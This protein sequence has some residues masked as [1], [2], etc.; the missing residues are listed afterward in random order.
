MKSFIICVFG[1]MG[2]S[3]FSQTYQ[4]IGF[5]GKDTLRM[6]EVTAD[7]AGNVVIDT[8]NQV[9]IIHLI[10]QLQAYQ[11][12]EAHFNV[13]DRIDSQ[14][15]FEAAKNY[16]SDSLDFN[17]L[18]HTPL[19]KRYLEY[20]VG[21]YLQTSQTP[22]AFSKAFVPKVKK[23]IQRTAFDYPEVTVYLVNNLL[24]FFSQYGLD[25]TAIEV[26][27]YA[28]GSDFSLGEPTKMAARILKIAHLIDHP[29]PTVVGLEPPATPPSFTLLFFYESGCSNCEEQIAA[30]K[31]RYSEL[32]AKGYRVASL[33][34]DVNKEVFAYHSKDFPW[35]DKLCDFQGF[36][37][38]N[39]KNY[40]VSFTPCIFLLDKDGIVKGFYA[41]LSDILRQQN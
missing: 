16:V 28:Y 29:A 23:V 26:A 5:A 17:V 38:E 35:K 25:Q 31:K 10:P 41:Q 27:E 19:W 39:F 22:E 18:Y 20:W 32:Q 2:V 14:A 8:K 15:K 24:E 7:Q 12:V 4:V 3:V 6:G 37:G 40:G 34:A 33:S 30:F 9:G 13:L 36:D 21:F 11:E 1:L